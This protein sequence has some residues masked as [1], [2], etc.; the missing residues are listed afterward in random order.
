M[1][2]SKF[3]SVEKGNIFENKPSSEVHKSIFVVEQRSLVAARDKLFHV[4]IQ[5]NNTMVASI[6]YYDTENNLISVSWMQ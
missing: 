2:Q 6:L 5:R 3:V 4:N 1:V